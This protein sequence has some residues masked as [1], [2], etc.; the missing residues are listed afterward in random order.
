MAAP[1]WVTLRAPWLGR[2]LR[3]LREANAL[4]L[5]LYG[6]ADEHRRSS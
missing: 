5:D 2:Q 3:Q 6:V 1:R 4:L